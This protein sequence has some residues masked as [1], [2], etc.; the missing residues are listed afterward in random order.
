MGASRSTGTPTPAKLTTMYRAQVAVCDRDDG[1]EDGVVSNPAAC[2]FDPATVRC[3]AG[4]NDSSCLTESEIE[5]VN[6]IRSD[7][8]LTDGRTVYPRFGIGDPSKGF[9]VFMPLGP[10]GAPTAS[11]FLGAG[12]LQYIVSAIPR[13]V[14]R[15]SMA[16]ATFVTFGRLLI[17]ST[18]SRPTR[19]RSPVTCVRGRR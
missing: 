11:A 19:R 17:V 2:R 16:I 13:T 1:L 12:H 6:T 14:L 3:P 5:A 4:T 18:I 10:A 15:R 9:G 7:L 8:Q